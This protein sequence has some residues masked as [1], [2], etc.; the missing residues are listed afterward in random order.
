[1]RAVER[2]QLQPGSALGSGLVIALSTLLPKSGIDA[3][4]IISGKPGDPWTRD[5]ARQSE[6]AAFK[7]VAPGSNDSAAI[8]LVSDGESN[9]GPELLDAA[10]LAAERGVRVYTV[11]VGTTEG[12]VLAVEGWSMR[13]R[14]DEAKLKQVADITRG[15]YFRAGSARDLQQ[16]YKQL[17]A[18]LAMGKGREMEITALFVALGMSFAIYAAMI[19]M[20][21][22]NRIL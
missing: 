7:P 12:A 8:V 3:Q 13:V 5:W 18:K 15:Q 19:S 4:K 17:G 10:K 9:V 2:V 1:M 6:T 22:S 21:R 11:G 16:V 20:L 14:L